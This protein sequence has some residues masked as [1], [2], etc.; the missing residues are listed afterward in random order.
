LDEYNN[1][2][3]ETTSG[4]YPL[5]PLSS[6]GQS[7]GGSSDVGFLAGLSAFFQ[8]AANSLGSLLSQWWF[9]AIIGGLGLLG[10]IAFCLAEEYY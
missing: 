6:D 3:Y 1:Y 4:R 9:W 7:S 2:D 8:E 5:E 10:L